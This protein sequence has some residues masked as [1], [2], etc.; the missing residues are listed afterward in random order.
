MDRLPISKNIRNCI[1][2]FLEVRTELYRA[3]LLN[4]WLDGETV[5]IHKVSKTRFVYMEH[6][7]AGDVACVSFEDF[8]DLYM[9]KEF[10]EETMRWYF[11]H[12][13]EVLFLG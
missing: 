5:L 13:S 12:P 6:N 10:P 11:F 7:H 3:I 8:T 9:G 4:D 2:S 1:L